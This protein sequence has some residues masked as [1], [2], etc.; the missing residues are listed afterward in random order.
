MTTFPETDSRAISSSS[1]LLSL[2][3]ASLITASRAHHSRAFDKFITNVS[4]L[5]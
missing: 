1:R 5:K 4:A 3:P 2:T